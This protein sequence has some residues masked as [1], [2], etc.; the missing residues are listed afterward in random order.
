MLELKSG[1]KCYAKRLSIHVD[2]QELIYNAPRGT[3][4]AVI[5]MA[6]EKPDNNTGIAA[7]DFI[8]NNGWRHE[9]DD[10]TP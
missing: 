5:I 9:T 7:N 2:G 6:A 4:F 10:K 3:K 8:R 1:D